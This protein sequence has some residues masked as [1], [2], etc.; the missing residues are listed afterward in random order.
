MK[1]R[2][3]GST[4]LEIS[5]IGL[6]CMSL[7]TN[8]NEAIQT[9]HAALDSGINYL[10]T[11]DL[12]DFGQNEEIVGKAL[13]GRRDQ[14]ILATKVGNRWTASQDKW[15]WDPSKKHILHAVKDSLRRLNTDYIDLYQLHGGTI[16]DSYEET[17][18]AFEELVKEGY[19]RHYGI[20]SIRPNV[21]ERFVNHSAIQSVMMQYNLLERRPEEFFPLF[22]KHN[23][24]VIT[25][26]SVAKGLLSNHWKNKLSIKGYLNYS[27]Q[28]CKEMIEQLLQVTQD[29]QSLHSLAMHFILQ[30][31]AVTTLAIGARNK[32]QLVENLNAYY[33]KPL[34][35]QQLDRIND[36][37]LIEKY[38]EHR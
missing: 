28:E 6:G 8:A 3:L 37:C 7:G 26:G 29:E 35:S 22:E 1:K 23:I 10:D 9:I 16:E 25:R 5:E 38:K 13:K 31:R 30:H 4:Q 33:T 15:S 32:E 34:S 17:I 24:S 2:M 20:S 19:I 11:A 27:E 14:V 18:E 36:I 21:I 12:Y